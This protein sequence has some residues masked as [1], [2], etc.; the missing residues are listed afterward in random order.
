MHGVE[1]ELGGGIS[2]RIRP[3]QCEVE[4]EIEVGRSVATG[5]SV[6]LH[7]TANPGI[8]HSK[9]KGEEERQPY[10]NLLLGIGA[11]SRETSCRT[12]LSPSPPQG[13]LELRAEIE[14][15]SL[16]H[17]SANS[18]DWRRLRSCELVRLMNSTSLGRVINERQLYRHRRCAPWIQCDA[19]RIDLLQYCAW[20]VGQRHLRATSRKRRVLGRETI[21]MGELRAIL[22]SQNYRC[23]LTGEPLTPTNFA[24]D[25]IIPLAEGGDF[26]AANCQLVLKLVN[27]AKNTMSELAFVEMCRQVAQHRCASNMTSAN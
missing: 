27:R 9:S 19:K 15:D 26:T 23:A 17:A 3:C 7:G 18:H 14:S 10:T 11:R 21:S 1:I 5:A 22:K 2:G 20:L 6:L 13:E 12:A 24:L 25:H 16:A 4:P 8:A